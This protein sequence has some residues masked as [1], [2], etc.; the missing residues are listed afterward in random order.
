M[1]Y[2]EKYA[3]VGKLTT[4]QLLISIAARNNWNIDHLDVVTAFLNPDVD[5]DALLMELP[6][7]WPHMEG[8]ME[9]CPE[10]EDSGVVRLRKALYGL[11]QA[12]HLW[13]R[14]INPFLLSLD[15]VQ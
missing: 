10:G 9:D 4:L 15:F 8:L 3:P 7:G 14:H 11:K 13:Y 5:D 1:D 6:E 12:P 2:G